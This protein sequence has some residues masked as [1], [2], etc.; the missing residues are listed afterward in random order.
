[1]QTNERAAKRSY[2]DEL[3]ER[4]A[5]TFPG[6]PYDLQEAIFAFVEAEALQ[7]WKNGLA[8]GRRRPAGTRTSSP[9]A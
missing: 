6:Q 8:A 5:Q 3:L 1:M 7:S 4:V 2:K 9:R